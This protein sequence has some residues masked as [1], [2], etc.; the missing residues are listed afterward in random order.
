M[1]NDAATSLK[2][3]MRKLWSDHV[4]WTRCYI[5]PAVDGPHAVMYGNEAVWL[6]HCAL[7]ISAWSSW[8][9]S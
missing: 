1:M 6:R 3:N 4:I 9:H 2:V 7:V 5:I 8:R